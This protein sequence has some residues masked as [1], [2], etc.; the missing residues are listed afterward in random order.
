MN[1]RLL[2]ISMAGAFVAMF[3]FEWVFHGIIMMPSYAS[4]AHLWR[5][6]DEMKAMFTFCV[7]RKLLM[8][9]VLAWIFSY[10]YEA[11]GT[12]IRTQFGMYIGLLMGL[13]EFGAYVYMPIPMGMA[14]CWLAGYT[15]MGILVA[16]VVAIV[17]DR[18]KE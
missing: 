11:K 7:M 13:L 1:G 9:G 14:I 18:C 17:H 8:A 16:W 5:S 6:Q 3:A 12:G 10:V 2:A 4:T 15:L